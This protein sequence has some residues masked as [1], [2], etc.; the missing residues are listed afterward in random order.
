MFELKLLYMY[1]IIGVYYGNNIAPHIGRGI[2]VTV[3]KLLLRNNVL[4]NNDI[5]TK[6]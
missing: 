1:C 3:M 6:Y 2:R 4:I 5:C